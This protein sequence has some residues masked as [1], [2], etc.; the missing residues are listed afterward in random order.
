MRQQKATTA[1]PCRCNAVRAGD[2]TELLNYL[3]A[4]IVC[5]SNWR[6][7]RRLWLDSNNGGLLWAVLRLR[8][9]RVLNET[10]TN[11]RKYENN[12]R[13]CVYRRDFGRVQMRVYPSIHYILRYLKVFMCTTSPLITLLPGHS[14]APLFSINVNGTIDH[15]NSVAAFSQTVA[16]KRS[17]THGLACYYLSQH[18]KGAT[19]TQIQISLFIHQRI[20]LCPLN[21]LNVILHL[22]LIYAA[23]HSALLPGCSRSSYAWSSSNFYPDHHTLHSNPA[24]CVWIGDRLPRRGWATRTG[25]P[26]SWWNRVIS[27][28]FHNIKS[29]PHKLSGQ[30]PMKIMSGFQLIG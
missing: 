25:S 16:L 15:P 29:H 18:S 9:S 26:K 13:V 4:E 23:L 19:C 21:G 3:W 6:L 14:S 27:N 30:V 2:L 7:E 11:I 24:K 12:V 28:R 10:Q 5:L 22:C 1:K 8:R 20:P 17:Q